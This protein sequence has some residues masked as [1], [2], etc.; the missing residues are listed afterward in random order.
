MD[1]GPLAK[2][3]CSHRNIAGY[4]VQ[5]GLKAGA[6]VQNTLSVTVLLRGAAGNRLPTLPSWD[7]RF[8]TKE[9]VSEDLHL[10]F[11]SSPDYRIHYL[12]PGISFVHAE[13]LY[14]N[15][16][17][18]HL[19]R[20]EYPQGATFNPGKG[21]KPLQLELTNAV[22]QTISL[23]NA[24]AHGTLDLDKAPQ[25]TLL[26]VQAYQANGGNSGL[27]FVSERCDA[28]G[29]LTRILEQNER[30]ND[31]KNV[32]LRFRVN[33]RTYDGAPRQHGLEFLTYEE[34]G[35][36]ALC[37]RLPELAHLCQQTA[38]VFQALR[39]SGLSHFAAD[40]P[41]EFGPFRPLTMLADYGQQ[42]TAQVPPTAVEVCSLVSSQPMMR[43]FDW[44][45]PHQAKEK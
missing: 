3:I 21:N 33:D 22:K 10:T 26:G 9:S 24:S 14:S 30:I 28:G 4:A 7:R 25:A 23:Q 15:L 43:Q 8:G 18:Y 35:G 36:L 17:Q 40:L 42:K 39:L 19:L 38:P 41:R 31:G 16:E 1:L 20:F 13:T 2:P 12:F 11:G 45:T 34:Y 5:A 44:R 27:Q 6:G 29:W 37:F 32:D